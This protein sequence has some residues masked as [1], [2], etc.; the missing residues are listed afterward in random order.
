M[1][2]LGRG[3]GLVVVSLCSFMADTVN[4][5]IVDVHKRTILSLKYPTICMVRGRQGSFWSFFDSRVNVLILNRM[6]LGLGP[7]NKNSM[8]T[9]A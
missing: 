1:N 2:L 9:N 4:D 5:D 7:I 8:S 6:K 3:V